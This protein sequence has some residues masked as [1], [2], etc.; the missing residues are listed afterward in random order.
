MTIR[1]TDICIYPVKSLGGIPK[2]EAK[3]T[4][5]GL[6]DDRRWLIVDAAGKFITQ[7]QVPAMAAFKVLDK[8]G[9]GLMGDG[10]TITA[11]DGKSI[12]VSSATTLSQSPV[13]VIVWSDTVKAQPVS[14]VADEWL[15]RHLGLTCH[16]VY[17][18]EKTKRPGQ[19]EICRARF[20]HQLCRWLSAAA[21][22][23]V[24][25]GRSQ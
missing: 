4:R 6:K 7:R 21:K 20:D 25:A 1:V 24:L 14:G 11:P 13:D 18:P 15:S 10:I 2:T 8:C 12:S 9:T 16:L 19:S 23:Q 3:V 17:M 22:Q 5:R